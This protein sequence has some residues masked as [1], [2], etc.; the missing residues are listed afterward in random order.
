M[1]IE[2]QNFKTMKQ[3]KSNKQI[4]DALLFTSIGFIGGMITTILSTFV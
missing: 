4:Q 2:I 3:G 1:D